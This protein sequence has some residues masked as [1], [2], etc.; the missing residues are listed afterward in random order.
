MNVGSKL[1]KFVSR[2]VFALKLIYDR[3]KKIANVNHLLIL[4]LTE[5]ILHPAKSTDML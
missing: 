2:L 4:F 1:L 5:I 3:C